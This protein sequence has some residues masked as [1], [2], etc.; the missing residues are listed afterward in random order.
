MTTTAE[1]VEDPN[2]YLRL[3]AMGC[4]AAQGFLIGRPM[5]HGDVADWITSL[6]R[7]TRAGGLVI[8]LV[9]FL[10]AALS[11]PLFR[12]RLSEL[13]SL[14]FA[15]RAIWWWSRFT[16]Q[17]VIIKF[18]SSAIPAWVAEGIHLYTL[19]PGVRVPG[20]EPP[21]PRG[22][23]WRRWEPWPTPSL[24]A[25]NHGVMPAS[26]WATSM[27]GIRA[28]D[29]FSNS[30]VVDEARLLFLGDIFR[31]PRL[32]AVRPTCFSAGDV[33]LVVGAGD[34]DAPGMW[35]AGSGAR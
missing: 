23:A 19:R 7:T 33:A 5:P 2:A 6:P 17:T 11:V 16:L 24:I 18:P 10:V 29:G 21:H 20:D 25:A 4:E 12:G 32:V 31:H 15:P 1:G 27:A 30:A 35:Q 8:I 14:P 28:T 22:W 26:P 34:P 13:A 3:R 9:G